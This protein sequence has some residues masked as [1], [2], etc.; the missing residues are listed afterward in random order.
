MS[1]NSTGF[2]V[3][4]KPF[5]NHIATHKW[6]NLALYAIFAI[7]V[8]SNIA[9]GLA[10]TMGSEISQ[11][12]SRT[13]DPVL[14]AYETRILQLRM[15]VDRLHSQQYLQAGNLN[16]QL[17]EL[18]QRQQIITEQNQFIRVLAQKAEDLG[19]TTAAL[20][21]SDMEADP[22]TTGSIFSSNLDSIRPAEQIAE[23]ETSLAR[24]SA[25]TDKVLN[26]ISNDARL[27]TDKI[28]QQLSPL[29]ITPAPHATTTQA[30][31][32]PFIPAADAQSPT[33]LKTNQTYNA[34]LAFAQARTALAKA[35]I[36]Y[37][38]AR[39]NRISSPFGTRTDPF[40]GARAFHTGIDYPAPFGTSVFTTGQGKVVYAGLKG[41]YGKFIEVEHANGIVSRYAHLSRILVSVGQEVSPGAKIGE[42][43]SSGRS[44]GAHLH[45]EIRRDQ[46]ALNPQDFLDVGRRLSQYIS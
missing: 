21:S 4:K 5:P 31:G 35:P 37:P 32:G 41:G 42:V 12:W 7:L 19:L 13:K 10:L 40:G 28:L 26:S 18:L 16:L 11:L 14:V 25:E 30:M 15:E 29:G 6:R 24:I 39:P 38:F 43:G 45:F 36:H 1:R 8:A 9:M 27:S 20:S 17:Q 46:T 2:G 22:L 44:T 33:A 34:L 3:Q 23:I